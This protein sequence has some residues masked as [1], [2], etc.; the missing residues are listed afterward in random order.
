MFWI[1]KSKIGTE[2]VELTEKNHVDV[3]KTVGDW[4]VKVPVYSS[5][6]RTNEVFNFLVKSEIPNKWIQLG[7][8]LFI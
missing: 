1:E 7:V 8:S 3:A 6:G 5:L 4:L 2:K